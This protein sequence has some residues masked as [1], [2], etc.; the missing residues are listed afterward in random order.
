MEFHITRER[1]ASL[2]VARLSGTLDLQS[3]E[4]CVLALL[5]FPGA[6]RSDH[7]LSDHS[8]LAAP[9]TPPDLSSF[10]DFLGT[11]GD[12]LTG[13]RWA[14]VTAT[15]ASYGMMRALSVGAE[16]IGL[17]VEVFHDATAARA[18]LLKPLPPPP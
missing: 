12:D 15:S 8:R 5:S 4:A 14:I 17:V 3:M 13:R 2:L 18:W 10:L 7:I 11:R 16:R 6:G 1:D 9:I